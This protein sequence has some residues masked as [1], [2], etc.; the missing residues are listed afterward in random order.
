MIARR[1][2][3][4]KRKHVFSRPFGTVLIVCGSPEFGC[5]AAFFMTGWMQVV[6]FGTETGGRD[7]FQ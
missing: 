7:R 1:K 2:K 6:P 4:F 3:R 5:W